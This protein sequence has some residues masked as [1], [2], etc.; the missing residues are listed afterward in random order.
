MRKVLMGLAVLAL[1]VFAGSTAQVLAQNDGITKIKG[2]LY[3]FR[4]N[5]HF[6]VFYVTSDGI[7]VT[8]PI[9]DGAAKRLLAALKQRFSQPVK[10]LILSHEHADH[11]SG[12]K[13]F[14]D[15]GAEV[16]AHERAKQAIIAKNVPTA[17]PTRTFKD[18]M[19]LKLGGKTI[20]LSYVGRNHTDNSIV[21]HFPAERAL[22]AVD[23]IPV[24]TVAFRT[25]RSS[26]MPD[27]I[28]SLERV[29]KMDFDI[30]VPGHGKVGTRAD[31]TLFKDYLSA[32]Y[33]QVKSLKAKGLSLAQV[34]AQID[35]KKYSHFAMFNQW[36]KLNVEGMYGL[37]K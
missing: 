27:W 9:N 24:K 35:L 17:V 29:E 23:F 28:R 15:A 36:G 22:F 10:Y 25:M 34:Q 21:M 32:L 12:G 7:V 11:V 13:V 37:V 16:I 8:D 30:L 20:N 14:A 19:T 3:R 4:N 31:V 6:S 5:F 18:K 26:Y 1:V 2:D 33:A